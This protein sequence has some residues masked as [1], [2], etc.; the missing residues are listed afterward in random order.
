VTIR[1]TF[2]YVN[3]PLK[4][5]RFKISLESDLIWKVTAW[6]KISN[7][8]QRSSLWHACISGSLTGIQLNSAV[9][10]VVMV[11]H[12][13]C[14]IRMIVKMMILILMLMMVMVTVSLTT[15]TS[16]IWRRQILL[17]SLVQR[18][19]NQTSE[20]YRALFYILELAGRFSVCCHGNANVI[21][22]PT[23]YPFIITI[24]WFYRICLSVCLSSPV[25]LCSGCILMKL[26]R[27]YCGGSL[28]AV[29]AWQPCPLWEP[30]TSHPILV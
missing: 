11:I 28:T 7:W 20:N 18:W 1:D 27:G 8:H 3:A 23:F 10:L 22:Q 24:A 6:F 26:G 9:L 14:C 15:V 13:S 16:I 4:L 25:C 17:L 30:S 19:W 12:C 21:M 29:Q 2:S 5:Q